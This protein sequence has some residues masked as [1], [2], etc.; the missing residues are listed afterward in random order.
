M[1]AMRMSV[2]VSRM[3]EGD[4]VV[5][6][7]EKDSEGDALSID[8]K[9]SLYLATRGGAVALDLPTGTFSVGTPFDAQ[10]GEWTYCLFQVY[11]C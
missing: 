7:S 5:N 9:E 4:R 3:R 1:G 2:I 10:L 6:A 8:W 11:G